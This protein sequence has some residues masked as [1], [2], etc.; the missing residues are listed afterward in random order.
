[1]ATTGR[2]IHIVFFYLAEGA[3]ADAA[4][5]IAAGCQTHLPGIPGVLRLDVGYPAGTPRPV[6]DNSYGVALHVEFADQAGHDIYQDHPSHLQ[7]IAENKQ[8]WSRV[9]VYD[10]ITSVS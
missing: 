7:F 9:Q 1:M 10:Y 4:Q 5:K 2:F 6:V 8:Y 3:D